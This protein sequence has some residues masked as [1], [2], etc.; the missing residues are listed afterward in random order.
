[1]AEGLAAKVEMTGIGGG[2]MA[3]FGPWDP[4]QE[5]KR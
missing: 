3:S 5:I 2:G 1:M 4:P